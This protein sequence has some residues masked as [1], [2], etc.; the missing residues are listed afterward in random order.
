MVLPT[1]AAGSMDLPTRAEGSMDLPTRA[2][3]SL[4]LALL[5]QDKALFKAPR[6]TWSTDN[7][8]M[9]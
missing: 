4:D 3:G 6:E 1:R 7:V 2:E 9:H 8:T 5:L